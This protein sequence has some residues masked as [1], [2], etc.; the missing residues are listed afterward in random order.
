VTIAVPE[1]NPVSQAESAS[2]A[3]WTIGNYRLVRKLGKTVFHLVGLNRAGAVFCIECS[4][5]KFYGKTARGA[6]LAVP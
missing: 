4:P 5:K 2:A 6:F 3:P 1:L